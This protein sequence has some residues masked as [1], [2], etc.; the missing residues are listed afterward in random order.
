M[1]EIQ[2]F[3]VVCNC[4][5]AKEFL[6]NLEILY[7]IDIVYSINVYIYIFKYIALKCDNQMCSS[8]LERP[9]EQ[10]HIQIYIFMYNIFTSGV[11]FSKQNIYANIEP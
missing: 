1:K 7:R 11:K 6:K 5:T 3:S 2:K 10:K 9:T 4:F 8:T